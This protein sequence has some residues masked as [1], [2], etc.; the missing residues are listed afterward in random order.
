MAFGLH[1]A[2]TARTAETHEVLLNG[3]GD[4][5]WELVSA[6][7][8]NPDNTPGND[9]AGVYRAVFKRPV[10]DAQEPPTLSELVQAAPPEHPTTQI[11]AP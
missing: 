4:E 5:G 9:H 8:V 7:L 10:E 6:V 2:E 3:L 11:D 1:R